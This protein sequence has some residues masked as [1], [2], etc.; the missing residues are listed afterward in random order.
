[1]AA[2]SG[3]HQAALM[4]RLALAQ[5]GLLQTVLWVL[6]SLVLA[7]TLWARLIAE[8]RHLLQRP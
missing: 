1:V 7:V 3:L 6:A 8:T 4:V 2:A 5:A